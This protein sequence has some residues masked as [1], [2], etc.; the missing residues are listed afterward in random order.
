MNDPLEHVL[1]YILSVRTISFLAFDAHLYG[2]LQQ[3]ATVEMAI[4]CHEDLYQLYPE[5]ESSARS[6]STTCTQHCFL[7]LA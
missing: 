1:D 4:T 6:R 3:N 2:I 7:R 5:G